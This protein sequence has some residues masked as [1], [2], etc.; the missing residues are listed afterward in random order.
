M[1]NHLTRISHGIDPQPMASKVQRHHQ[2]Y[3]THVDQDYAQ[4]EK[5]IRT[6]FSTEEAERLMKKRFQIINVGGS[7]PSHILATLLSVSLG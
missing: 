4:V 7:C 2:A 3:R 1:F 5:H 6:N